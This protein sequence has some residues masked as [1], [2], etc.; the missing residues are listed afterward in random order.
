[1]NEFLWNIHKSRDPRCHVAEKQEWRGRNRSIT[2]I[3]CAMWGNM[4]GELLA[5]VFSAPQVDF[6]VYLKYL[7]RRCHQTDCW[8]NLI[9][10]HAS[11]ILLFL[12]D[13]A[14]FIGG[15]IFTFAW[16]LEDWTA[17][18]GHRRSKPRGDTNTHCDARQFENCRSL[19][20]KP[21]QTS[22]LVFLHNF[23]GMLSWL[24]FGWNSSG[25]TPTP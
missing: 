24:L 14:V 22:G 16:I 3:T 19:R 8:H 4:C 1:M 7:W 25:W 12:S 13:D 18:R 9:S 5:P 17:W 15:E 6:V 10:T 2:C 11:L 21:P 23:R 20:W